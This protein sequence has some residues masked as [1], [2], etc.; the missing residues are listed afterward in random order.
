MMALIVAI[1]TAFN[2]SD[3]EFSS[4]V[5]VGDDVNLKTGIRRVIINYL[6]RCPEFETS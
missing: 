3:D 6:T 5:L 4:Q 1:N 2:R